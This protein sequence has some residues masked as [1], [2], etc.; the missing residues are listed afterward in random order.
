MN[1]SPNEDKEKTVKAARGKNTGHIQRTQDKADRRLVRNNEAIRQWSNFF[2][3][4]IERNNQARIPQPAKISFKIEGKIE[5]SLN[6]Q[7]F[8]ECI[9]SRP[10]TINITGNP[11]DK[12]I[13]V[14]DEVWIYAK[15]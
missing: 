4:Q 5:T 12:M 8:E 13:I 10:T 3:V 1:S 15:K 14:S 9:N 2:K 6:L 11:L 7:N